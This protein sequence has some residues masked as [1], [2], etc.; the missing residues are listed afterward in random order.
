[1]I[2]NNTNI[3]IPITNYELTDIEIISKFCSTFLFK[4]Q[5][6]IILCAII[7][8]LSIIL[9]YFLPKL[10][11][12]LIINSFYGCV[13]IWMSAIIVIQHGYQ[14]DFKILYVLLSLLIVI[15]GYIF[16]KRYG[17]QIEKFINE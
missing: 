17:K 16:F 2:I 13:F 7:F 1:M 14:F 10:E 9:K 12:D 5:N 3:S 4:F 8:I 6:I 11:L 15:L